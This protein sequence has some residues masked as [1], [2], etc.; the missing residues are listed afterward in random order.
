M[1]LQ[2]IEIAKTMIFQGILAEYGVKVKHTLLLPYLLL[3]SVMVFP[4]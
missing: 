1:V 4:S 3:K 2:V